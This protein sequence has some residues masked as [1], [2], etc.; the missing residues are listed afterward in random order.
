[1]SRGVV[2]LT[3]ATRED[4]AELAARS[5]FTPR[6]PPV[7]VLALAGKVDGQVIAIGGILFWP[8]GVKHAFADIGPEA[9]R[10]PV[11]LHK[12]GLA[13]L[14]LA[15]EHDL[16]ELRAVAAEPKDAAVRWL[17]RLGFKPVE[18]AEGNFVCHL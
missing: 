16:R 5:E 9:R 12:A 18:G 1:M 14:K 2:T 6:T 8:N 15:R 11:A 10:Y 3:P 7:R 17:T 4:F 13:V